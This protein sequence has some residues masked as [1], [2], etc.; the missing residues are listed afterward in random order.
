MMANDAFAKQVDTDPGELLGVKA[1]S[2]KW[3]LRKTED[4]EQFP[5]IKSIEDGVREIGVALNLA[6]HDAQEGISAFLE[7]RTPNWKGM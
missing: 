1:S 6:T 5:W 4:E 3:K 2:L 7:K